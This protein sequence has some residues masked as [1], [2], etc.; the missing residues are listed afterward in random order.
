MSIGSLPSALTRCDRSL[1]H[2]R[3]PYGPVPAQASIASLPQG[4]AHEAQAFPDSDDVPGGDEHPRQRDCQPRAGTSVRGGL[5]TLIIVVSVLLNRISVP[6][7]GPSSLE[8]RVLL[9]NRSTESTHTRSSTHRWASS[10]SRL[11]SRARR[12]RGSTGTLC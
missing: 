4:C 7:T 1:K 5:R 6:I 8:V 11:R 10:S 12:S 3:R 2:W 9:V